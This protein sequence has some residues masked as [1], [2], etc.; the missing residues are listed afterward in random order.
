MNKED[1]KK[2]EFYYYNRKKI[3]Y[4]HPGESS[5]TTHY[6]FSKNSTNKNDPFHTLVLNEEQLKD[7]KKYEIDI[8]VILLITLILLTA[9]FTSLH[10]YFMAVWNFC[11]FLYL[12]LEKEK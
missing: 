10:I 12:L 1:L 6:L 5:G 2:D 8:R 7:L 11:M 3:R 4:M 9:I